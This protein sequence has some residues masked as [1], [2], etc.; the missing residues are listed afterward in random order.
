MK[1]GA[2]AP[3]ISSKQW[4]D[5]KRMAYYLVR[6]KPKPERLTELG[7]LL[8]RRAFENLR[9]FGKSLSA[10]LRGARIGADGVVLWEEEDYCSPPLAMERAAVLDIYF[11]NIQV[12]PVHPGEGWSRIRELPRLFPTLPPEPHG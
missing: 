5:G 12:E 3:P 1:G 10:G 8:E 9:P 6:A 7:V 2:G 11:D 4:K